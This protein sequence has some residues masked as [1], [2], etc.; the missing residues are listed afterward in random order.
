MELT[1]SG[2][3]ARLDSGTPDPSLDSALRTSLAPGL[4]FT[5]FNP[6]FPRSGPTRRVCPKAAWEPLRGAGAPDLS[7]DRPAPPK[8]GSEVLKCC[9]LLCELPFR[10]LH[11]LPRRQDA[12]PLAGRRAH[13][14][15]TRTRALDVLPQ[16]AGEV[17]HV[18]LHFPKPRRE[19]GTNTRSLPASRAPSPLRPE[20][21]R[22]LTTSPGPD[23]GSGTRP[24]TP[25][26]L[27]DSPRPGPGPLGS[28]PSPD[29]LFSP[30]PETDVGE[31]VGGGCPAGRT[32]GTGN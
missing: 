21:G 5:P 4:L 25:P 22:Q 27:L 32:R 29:S 26:R 13:E 6:A 31:R 2:L 20:S 18:P 11:S 10:P 12:E 1:P 7:R 23:G 15:Y 17:P 3:S 8:S 19:E 30:G 14:S 16:P 9:R 28:L 24:P